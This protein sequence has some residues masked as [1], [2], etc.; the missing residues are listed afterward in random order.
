[1]KNAVASSANA[2]QRLIWGDWDVIRP[3]VVW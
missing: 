3:P 2:R 1:M